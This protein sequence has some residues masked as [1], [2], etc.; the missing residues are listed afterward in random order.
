MG[1]DP[2]KAAGWARMAAQAERA[3]LRLRNRR[4]HRAV[5]FGVQATTYLQFVEDLA[6][7][8]SEAFPLDTLIFA[9]GTGSE[10]YMAKHQPALYEH[11]VH[12]HATT[13]QLPV[14]RECDLFVTAAHTPRVPF[15]TVYIS[16]GQPSKRQSFSR[17]MLEAIDALFVLGPLQLR[18]LVEFLEEERLPLPPSLRLVPTGYGKSDS[19]L[20]GRFDGNAIAASWGLNASRPTVL[21]APAFNEGASL[22]EFGPELVEN[23]LAANAYNVIAKLPEDVFAPDASTATTGA[24]DWRARFLELEA[25]NP[26]FHLVRDYRVDR[27]LAVADVLVTCVSSVSFEMLA[28]GKPVIFVDTPRFY[29]TY[30]KTLF[31]DL[32]TESWRQR[33]TVNA[34]REFGTVVDDYRDLPAVVSNVLHN[35]Q[36]YVRSR[37]DLQRELLYHPGHALDAML[38]NLDAMLRAKPRTPVTLVGNLIRRFTRRA[39]Q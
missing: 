33:T 30:L 12:V 7:A 29:D 38:L 25:T 14:L 35:P 1:F 28:L 10:T 31:P 22:R 13:L 37:S 6:L 3:N 24:T 4:P 21:Y 27:A 18:A 36:Q 19:V 15:P 34:G 8:W 23:L 39:K 26:S 17:E 5:A 16:H 11:S 2:A 20:S 32:P 9:H